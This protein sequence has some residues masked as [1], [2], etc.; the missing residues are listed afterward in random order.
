M[1]LAQRL[2]I[3]WAALFA[4]DLLSG[5]EFWSVWPGIAFLA[6]LGLLAAPLLARRWLDVQLVRCVVIA[7]ALALVNLASGSRE[8]WFL[9]PAGAV[10]VAVLLRRTWRASS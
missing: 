1:R 8:P 7:A 2:A 10:L 6:V 4:I 5:A 3:V 9:W